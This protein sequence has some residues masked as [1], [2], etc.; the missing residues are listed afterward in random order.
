MAT[1]KS[2]VTNRINITNIQMQ[3]FFAS[4]FFFIFLFVNLHM[5]LSSAFNHFCLSFP[6]AEIILSFTQTPHI[7]TTIHTINNA[8]YYHQ[9]IILVP[10]T[11]TGAIAVQE[12]RAIVYFIY[13]SLM[14][15]IASIG[16]SH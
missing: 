9:C 11:G 8:T 4:C 5:H 6:M 10:P 2:I 7:T 16:I 14:T 1:N 15:T 13:S 3:V 12:A